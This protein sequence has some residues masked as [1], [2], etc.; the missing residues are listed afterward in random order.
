M[1]NQA[2]KGDKPRPVDGE[3]YRNG[4]EAIFGKSDRFLKVAESCGFD[5][6]GKETEPDEDQ[7]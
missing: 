4:Y 2:G 7:D 1:S 5:K 6:D 3:A